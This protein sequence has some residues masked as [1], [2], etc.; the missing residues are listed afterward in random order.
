MINWNRQKVLVKLTIILL[1]FKE[2]ID[3]MKDFGDMTLDK[4]DEILE[5]VRNISDESSDPI[6]VFTHSFNEL[7][8]L[9]YSIKGI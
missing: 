6:D 2:D 3:T 1:A 8:K 4:R 5:Q 9:V 7:S